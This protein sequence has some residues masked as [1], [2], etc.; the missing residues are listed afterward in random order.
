MDNVRHRRRFCRRNLTSGG[1]DSD[2]G[3]RLHG[4][5]GP[6]DWQE[7]DLDRP[8]LARRAIRS[9]HN[10]KATTSPSSALSMAVRV[11]RSASPSSSASTAKPALW[12]TA[13]L[14]TRRN[15]VAGG[16]AAARLSAVFGP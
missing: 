12:R 14:P 10:L 13:H 3:D 1:C 15:L 6:L 7:I 9:R 11:K 16:E 2:R 4:I 8:L 5:G